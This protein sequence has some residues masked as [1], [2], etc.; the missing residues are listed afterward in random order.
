MGRSS[1]AA[2]QHSIGSTVS[3]CSSSWGGRAHR[4]GAGQLALGLVAARKVAV[5]A[6][7]GDR[8]QGETMQLLAAAHQEL[9]SNLLAPCLL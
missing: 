8:Q 5:Q 6:L 1:C 9:A 3:R 4:Q 2:T 7:R